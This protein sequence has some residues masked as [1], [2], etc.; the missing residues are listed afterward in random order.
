MKLSHIK[1]DFSNVG[2]VGRTKEV[3]FLKECLKGVER[4]SKQLVLVRGPAGSGKS[5]L[6]RQVQQVQGGP[7]DSDSKTGLLYGEGKYTL[8]QEQE[9]YM[10][11][12]QACDS[13][14][15]QLI[16]MDRDDIRTR[17]LK[18]LGSGKLRSLCNTVKRLAVFL[19]YDPEN[20]H[21]TASERGSNADRSRTMPVN[22]IR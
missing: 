12:K 19:D 10:A 17:L 14:C 11:I 18:K 9:P 6:V 13:I 2:L 7:I 20:Q 22:L 21:T 16:I 4:D 8:K 5:A 15:S 1:P 3:I